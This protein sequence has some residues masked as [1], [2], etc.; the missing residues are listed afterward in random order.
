MNPAMLG[1]VYSGSA[2][3]RVPGV[4]PGDRE[5]DDPMIEVRSHIDAPPE[6]IWPVLVDVERW[7]EWTPSVTRLEKLDAGELRVGQ[8]VRIEQPK[9]PTMTWQVTD[10]EPG[11]SF[12]WSAS[13][14]GVT[15]VG[16][17]EIAIDGSRSEIR[18]R[19]DQH[20]FLAPLV[21]LLAGRR[22]RRYMEQ[23]AR[24]LKQRTESRATR[25]D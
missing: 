13:R 1:T 5:E 8:Q 19:I 2:T 3:F 23:E 6:Q 9:L 11:R 15:T 10:V 16:T 4:T 20:G 25:R 7:P 18:L 21:Q 24:G 22:T 17:H 14:P 12:S